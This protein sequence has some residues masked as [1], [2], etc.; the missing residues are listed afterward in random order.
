[1]LE[2]LDITE[3]TIAM[4]STGR[5]PEPGLKR[6]RDSIKVI[7]S[8]SGG[9]AALDKGIRCMHCNERYYLTE[10]KGDIHNLFCTEC[11]G[12]TPL[13]TIK[14]ARGLSAPS[15][16]QQ[17]AMV[18]SRNNISGIDRKPKR[19]NSKKNPLEDDLIKQGYTV[20]NSDYIEP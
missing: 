3:S 18:Q 11:G 19:I 6:K 9:I 7:D 12:L 4:S 2:P 5:P 20:I 1:M 16:Q 8:S 15:I 10:N 14:H 13:R 17:T